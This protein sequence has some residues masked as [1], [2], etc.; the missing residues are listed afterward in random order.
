MFN[1][2]YH[3]PSTDL[4]M[5]KTMLEFSD[6]L[7]LLVIVTRVKLA[8]KAIRGKGVL[9]I[10]GKSFIEIVY[11]SFLSQGTRTNTTTRY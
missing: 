1:P 9:L 6:I 7:K 2:I 11:I 3:N 10:S 5:I 8:N 4:V